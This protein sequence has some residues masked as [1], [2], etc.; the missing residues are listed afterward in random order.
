MIDREAAVVSD[1]PE[2]LELE[3]SRQDAMCLVWF[4]IRPD[5][6]LERKKLYGCGVEADQAPRSNHVTGTQIE[7]SSTIRRRTRSSDRLGIERAS[8][9]LDDR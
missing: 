6:V 4:V 8:T 1:V 9:D 5:Q 2:L 7:A 3:D